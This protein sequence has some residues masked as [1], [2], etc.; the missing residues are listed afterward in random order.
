MNLQRIFIKIC[1]INQVITPRVNFIGHPIEQAE[2]LFNNK[3]HIINKTEALPAA[4]RIVKVLEL[5]E[6]YIWWQH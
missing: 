6:Y 5:L 4:Y 2:I 3:K 1:E